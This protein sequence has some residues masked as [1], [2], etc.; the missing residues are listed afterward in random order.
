M[1]N[2]PKLLVVNKYLCDVDLGKVPR[3]QRWGRAQVYRGIH[4]KSCR[5]PR[6]VDLRQIDLKF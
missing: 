2:K 1:S 4:G 6:K 5:K 3:P